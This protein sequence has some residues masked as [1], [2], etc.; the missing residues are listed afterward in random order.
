MTLE[1]RHMSI[2]K[3][4]AA[5]TA[6]VIAGTLS[7]SPA[8]AATPP[9]SN[10]GGMLHSVC[11]IMA[12]GTIECWGSN[13]KGQLG[14]G[15]NGG[16]AVPVNHIAGT[17]TYMFPGDGLN[18]HM[19]AIKTNGTLW[20]WGYG[21]DGQVGNGS[22]TNVLTPVQVGTDNTWIGGAVGAIST[23]AIKEGG[24]LWCW[25]FNDYGQF[26][27][28]TYT[29]SNVP[30]ASS[31]TSVA[32]VSVSERHTC[33][34]KTDNT[35]WCFGGGQYGALGTGGTSDEPLPV[36]VSGSWKAVSVGRNP[37]TCAIKGDDTLWC[38]GT[39]HTNGPLLGIGTTLDTLV[40]VQVSGGGS[41]SSVTT[42]PWATCA[43]KSPDAS[44]WC[45]GDG[46][47]GHLGNNDLTFTDFGTPQLVAG[48]YA[49][50]N[51]IQ[52][53]DSACG[54]Q[55]NLSLWCW[56]SQ[57]D[58]VIGVAGAPQENPIPLALSRTLGGGLPETNRDG[59]SF[60]GVLLLLASALAAAG[61]G[62]RPRKGSLAK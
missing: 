31:L 47:Q 45:W 3:L 4:F 34:I 42:G 49:W 12:N 46:Y 18:K 43:V 39:S 2:K 25:G 41:W 58:G 38:W 5:V 62:L 20:C 55:T 23:C 36:Q 28:N 27:N 24:A 10:I 61:V 54:V 35:L 22:E 56:G 14:S 26:G 50:R 59:R 40:P 57:S 1:A 32:S 6:L 17:W 52:T 11:A 21:E 19:C 48:S 29:Y 60:N 13:S 15:I 16:E 30:V 7:I 37:Q 44:L 33:A 51:S 8:K 9:P 53:H